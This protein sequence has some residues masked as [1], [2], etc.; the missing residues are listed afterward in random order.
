M[1][2]V[3]TTPYV[4]DLGGR[5]ITEAIGAGTIVREYVG[6]DNMLRVMGSS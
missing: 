3:G 4:Y 2:P 6:I 5:L 1:V